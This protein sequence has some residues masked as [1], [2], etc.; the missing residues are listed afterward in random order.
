MIETS[1]DLRGM[2]YYKEF[3][4][5]DVRKDKSEKL[6]YRGDT[7]R[8]DISNDIKIVEQE[9]LGRY[10]EEKSKKHFVFMLTN[11]NFE[12]L[13]LSDPDELSFCKKFLETLISFSFPLLGLL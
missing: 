3:V 7:F 9:F 11:F 5:V 10:I 8:I 6:G 2:K 4:L 13:E 12:A 1:N